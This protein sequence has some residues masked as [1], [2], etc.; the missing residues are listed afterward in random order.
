MQNPKF[1]PI[2]I[3][4]LIHDDQIKE[5]GGSY[6]I[7]DQGLL[8]SALAQ[9][10]VTF[11]G[12]LLNPTLSAQAAAYLFSLVKNHAFIDGNKRTAFEV[13][14]TFLAV[15]GYDLILSE[16]QAYQLVIDIAEN[17]LNK[18]QIILILE[19]AIKP[20]IVE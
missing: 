16:D 9:P 8:E 3:V 20:R 17:K 14:I 5:H 6:G 2:E 12:Q 10:E 18:E 4:I 11:G 1:I 15:N 7:R 19:K 13:M